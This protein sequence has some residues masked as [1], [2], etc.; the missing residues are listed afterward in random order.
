MLCGARDLGGFHVEVALLSIL[1]E[2]QTSYRKQWNAQEDGADA[3]DLS[4]RKDTEDHEQWMQLDALVHEM[5]GQ[6][7][8]LKDAIAEQKENNP[9]D[10]IVVIELADANDDES[11][12]DGTDEG[13]ELEWES[14]Q[15]EQKSV[16]HLHE[17][18]HD[19]EGDQDGDAEKHKSPH[20]LKDQCVS[21]VEHTFDL[22]TA[23]SQVDISAVS[24]AKI[25]DSV[26]DQAAIFEHEECENRDE[27]NIREVA[28]RA[29]EDLPQLRHPFYG[30]SLNPAQVVAVG[31]LLSHWNSEHVPLLHAASERRAS[32]LLLQVLQLAGKGLVEQHSGTD[33]GRW[34]AEKQQQERQQP[35]PA[36]K[37]M[38]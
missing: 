13:N 34:H 12:C 29:A 20:V 1:V 11:G 15:S 10:V 30:F 22:Q 35:I 2:E 24:E 8:V 7:V 5:R 4:S 21:V 33:Q 16:A 36:G 14:Q 25:Q 31:D 27:E 18:E 26:A 32:N 19:T 17:G 28:A 37:A 9:A 6:N 38:L 3:A 23:P